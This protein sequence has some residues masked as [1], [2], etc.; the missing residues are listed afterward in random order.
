[1]CFYGLTMVASDIGESVFLN[2]SL[3]LGT[4]LPAIL[5][6]T[7]GLDKWGRKLVLSGCQIMAG[8]SLIAAG[9]LMDY[10]PLIPVRENVFRFKSREIYTFLLISDN[11]LIDW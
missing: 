11:S 3:V 2:F 1:M 7:Y 9:F 8:V 4:E 5:F 10:D 6:A